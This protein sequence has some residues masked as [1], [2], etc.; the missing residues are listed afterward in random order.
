METSSGLIS[1]IKDFILPKNNFQRGVSWNALTFGIMGVSGIVL[2]LLIITKYGAEILGAFNQVYA[3]YIFASQ[4]AVFGIYASVLKHISQYSEDR[5]VC[6]E[7]ITSA[8]IV[9]IIIGGLVSFLYY[10]SIPLAERL[11]S[12]ALVAK[13][14][15]FSV[16][17]L[18]CFALNKI[19]LAFL[20]GMRQMKAFALFTG[21]RYVM[22]PLFLLVFIIL[23]LPGFI[24]PLVFTLTEFVLLI[25]LTIFSF[26]FFSIASINQCKKWLKIHLPFGAKSLIG[27]SIIE[28]NSRIDVFMLG[29]FSSDKLVGIYSLAAIFADGFSQIPV[30]F[31]VNYNPLLTKLVVSKHLEELRSVIKSFLKKWIPF[32][33]MIAAI[34]VLIYP[35]MVKIISSDPEISKSWLVFAILMAGIMIRSGYAVFWE[36]PSQSG[37]PG[38]QTAMILLVT[39]TNIFLNYLLIPPW[40][41]SGAAIATSIS[42]VLGIFYQKLI[43]KKILGI[44]I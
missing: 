44:N 17:G 10:L 40:G 27:G 43:V 39:M 5:A 7:I 35:I 14:L 8:L 41:M 2:N 1:K 3:V 20:N 9:G 23:K 6:N 34:T 16:I 25:G 32:A 37:F 24:C 11:L 36:L 28:L 15:F 30:I 4:L 22:M 33:L 31:Q 29:I 26:R 19:L 42:L 21:F 38:H 13:G 18:W 12:S